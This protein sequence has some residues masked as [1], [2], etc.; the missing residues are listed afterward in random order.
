FWTTG[1]RWEPRSKTYAAVSARSADQACSQWSKSTCLWD[2][3]RE[4][5]VDRRVVGG[6]LAHDR[7]EVG[8]F[9]QFVAAFDTDALASDPGGLGPSEIA[10]AGGDVVGHTGSAQRLLVHEELE[11][12]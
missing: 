8:R 1:G 12:L 10:D 9:G 3:P 4:R 6:A 2:S 5:G 7:L 11:N